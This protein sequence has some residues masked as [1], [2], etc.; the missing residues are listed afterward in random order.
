MQKIFLA[1]L[2]IENRYF[3]SKFQPSD[4]LAILFLGLSAWLFSIG[5]SAQGKE[6]IYII[7]GYYFGRQNLLVTRDGKNQSAPPPVDSTK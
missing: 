4:F 5:E 1:A 3:S 7:L 6:I 2:A